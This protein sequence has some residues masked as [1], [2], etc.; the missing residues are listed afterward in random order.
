M[1]VQRL[2]STH[3]CGPAEESV[4]VYYHIGHLHT[5]HLCPVRKVLITAQEWPVVTVDFITKLSDSVY[6]TCQLDTG[7][8]SGELLY[9]VTSRF[10]TC[11]CDTCSHAGRTGRVGQSNVTRSLITFCSLLTHNYTSNT[12]SIIILFKFQLCLYVILHRQ[13][14]VK[15]S[16]CVC[17]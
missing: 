6:W 1:I 11:L 17:F 8:F 16:C 15:D 3:A 9:A 13:T 10:I 2:T 5:G 7:Q 12:K 4:A 14:F